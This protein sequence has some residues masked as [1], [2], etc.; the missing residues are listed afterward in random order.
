MPMCRPYSILLPVGFAMPPLLPGA[1]CALAAPFHPCLFLANE[2]IGGLLSVALSLG[3][4]PPGVTRHR[5]SA[6]PGLS[7]RVQA[8]PRP[9]DPLAGTAP[10]ATLARK[11][12]SFV[13]GRLWQQQGEQDAATLA[14]ND[15]VDQLG[16]EAALERD[17]RGELVGHIIA[18]TF[19]RDEETGIGP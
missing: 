19:E 15:A 7:S 16:A 4:P 8:P 5:R 1:R 11:T 17:D 12:N 14:I 2:D 9:P 13:P 3:S 6:E 18:E 10:S